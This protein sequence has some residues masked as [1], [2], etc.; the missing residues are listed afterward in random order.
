ME[1]GHAVTRRLHFNLDPL[2]AFCS[3]LEVCARCSMSSP[4]EGRPRRKRKRSHA[5][6]AAADEGDGNHTQEN[7]LRQADDGGED[8]PACQSCRR[9]KSRCS[10]QQPCEQCERLQVECLYDERRRPGFKTGAIESLSQRLANLEQMF[11][12]Q[13]LLLQGKFG[14]PAGDSVAAPTMIADDSQNALLAATAQV[15]EQSLHTAA[16]YKSQATIPSRAQGGGSDGVSHSQYAHAQSEAPADASRYDPMLPESVV[17]D[18]VVWYFDNIHRWIPVLHQRRFRERLN[19]PE[20]RSNIN[21]ILL[22]ITSLSLRFKRPSKISEELSEAISTR[23]RHAVILR[24]MEC[25]SVES[26]QAL[27]ILAFDIIGRGQGPSSWS[28]VGS[29][30]RTVEQLRLDA[31]STNAESSGVD[32]D[33]LIRRMTFLPRAKTWTEEEERRRV[34]WCVFMMDRFSS[35]ATGWSNSINGAG[36]RRRLPCEGTLWEREVPVQ[37]PYFG[38]ES[39]AQ[40][41]TPTSEELPSESD[42][43]EH[44][45]GF[46]FCLEA[47]DNLNLVTSFF[48]QRAVKFEGPQQVRLWLLKFRELDLRLVK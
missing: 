48:L 1:E 5:P 26:L 21:I 39:A 27:V 28:I 43:M 18:L 2:F 47:S 41:S 9:R 29:M 11:L 34:F 30:T 22:A 12:G 38:K 20:E 37:T 4:E 3:V 16:Q 36:L 17:L 15:R 44:I 19:S 35:V 24:S 10:K 14:I 33:Y 32:V 6:A 31:E 13:S 40:V 25:F 8:G 42:A 46:A 7:T 23:C 45:G